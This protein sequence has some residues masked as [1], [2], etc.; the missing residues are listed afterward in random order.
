[1]SE[2]VRLHFYSFILSAYNQTKTSEQEPTTGAKPVSSTA[3][4]APKQDTLEFVS[5][6]H[7]NGESSL[8]DEEIKNEL[9]QLNLNSN[10]SKIGDDGNE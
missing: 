7:E 3:S 9:K 4:P 5:D 8:N 6:D 10:A 1:V 2:I